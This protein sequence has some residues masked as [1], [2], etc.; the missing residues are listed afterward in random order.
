MQLKVSHQSSG[1]LI[2]SA[3]SLELGE[4]NSHCLSSPIYD[5]FVKAA[6]AVQDIG[7]A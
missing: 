7:C 1:T 3:Q 4:I 6:Q 2:L 5:I